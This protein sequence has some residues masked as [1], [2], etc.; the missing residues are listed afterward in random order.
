MAPKALTLAAMDAAA[1]S[2]ECND[3]ALAS[4]VTAADAMHAAK[5]NE[6]WLQAKVVWVHAL[7]DDHAKCT[8][9]RARWLAAH[10]Q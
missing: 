3:I 6:T 7:A 1:V 8:D 10:P 9:F 5:L 4:L 2:G